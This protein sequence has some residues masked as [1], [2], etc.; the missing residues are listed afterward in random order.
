MRSI[1][2]QIQFEGHDLITDVDV[3]WLYNFTTKGPSSL[4]LTLALTWKIRT[5]R[6]FIIY[7]REAKTSYVMNGGPLL[8]DILIMHKVCMLLLLPGLNDQNNKSNSFHLDRV[9]YR[10]IVAQHN[11]MLI[12]TAVGNIA[13]F[14][15]VVYVNAAY[16]N[17]LVSIRGILFVY[18]VIT[19]CWGKTLSYSNSIYYAEAVAVLEVSCWVLFTC[20]G[21]QWLDLIH[22]RLLRTIMVVAWIN[23]RDYLFRF[24]II[25]HVTFLFLSPKLLNVKTK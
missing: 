18:N 3:K 21:Q 9:L 10:P 1:V 22:C 5:A 11:S 13:S 14:L 12:T 23:H 2:S 24:S 4:L 16:K 6:N 7:K 25:W 20:R 8:I 17:N 15:H 19:T